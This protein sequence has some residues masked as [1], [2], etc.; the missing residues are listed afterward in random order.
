[1][2]D[3][4]TRLLSTLMVAIGVLI[5][6]RTVALGGGPLA[7]GILFGALFIAA[8]AARLHLLRKGADG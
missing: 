1:L 7:V 6:V 4:S 3:A 8:G 2:H 5:I